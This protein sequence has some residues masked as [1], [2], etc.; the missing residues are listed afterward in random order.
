MSFV[1][2]AILKHGLTTWDKSLVPQSEVARR[3]DA[4]R[5]Q[6]QQHGWDALVAY[7]DQLDSGNV[8]YLTNFHSY[9]PR[10]PALAVITAT[11]VDLIPK[12]AARDLTY[13]KDYT[14]AEIHECEA[15]LATSL[16]AVAELREV[17]NAKIGFVGGNTAPVAVNLGMKSVF[18]PGAVSDAG[19]LVLQLRRRKSAVERT[20]MQVVA[21]KAAAVL[22]SLADHVCAGMSELEVAAFADYAARSEGCM[23]TDVLVH[24]SPNGKAERWKPNSFPFAPVEPRLLVE[25]QLLGVYLAIQYHGYWLEVSE[26]ISIGE[27]SAEQ[28][29][30]M[31]IADAYLQEVIDESTVITSPADGRRAWI[32]GLGLDREEAPFTSRLS[33]ED[34]NG[35]VLGVHVA[36]ER[37]GAVFICGRAATVH[38][39][40]RRLLA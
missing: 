6:M 7:S 18:Q 22:D 10:H 5:L 32:H 30:G 28:I 27:P 9:E 1:R 40:K 8:A 31:R 29:D 37:G 21:M 13:I 2:L 19:D 17:K 34:A 3:I 23:D 20:L 11:T 33:E 25:G 35:D 39:S 16:A 15:D 38:D 36:V 14:W 26:S 4:V 12:V 24:R